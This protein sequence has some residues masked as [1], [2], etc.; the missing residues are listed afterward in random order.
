[1]FEGIKEIFT[2]LLE[3]TTSSII[4]TL[5]L[6]FQ[7]YKQHAKEQSIKNNLLAVRRILNKTL[8]ANTEAATEALDA[9]LA[10]LG[11]R[12][13]FIRLLHQTQDVIL[14]RLKQESNR[15]IEENVKNAQAERSNRPRSKNV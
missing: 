6:F 2:R 1:M 14:G 10:S 7:W 15:P 13:P 11:A 5:L 4:L 12:G 3:T 9:T 8:N